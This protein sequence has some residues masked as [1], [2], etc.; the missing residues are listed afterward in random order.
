MKNNRIN[1]EQN[2]LMDG[3]TAM[4]FAKSKFVELHPLKT[5]PEWFSRCVTIGYGKDKAGRF[6]VDFGLTPKAT[7]DAICIFQVSVDRSTAETNILINRGWSE[8]SGADLQG[9]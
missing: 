3:V 7:N 9:F 5:H 4:A 6:V 1:L 8:F 2:K